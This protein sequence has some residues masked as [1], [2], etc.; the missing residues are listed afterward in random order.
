MA[1]EEDESTTVPVRQPGASYLQWNDAIAKFL[2]DQ[3]NDV[4]L[5]FL[6][7][8]DIIEI[9][10]TIPQL[11]VITE[12]EEIWRDFM[13]K[14]TNG[15]PGITG[16][17]QDLVS[18]A[19]YACQVWQPVYGQRSLRVGK[20]EIPLKY[21]P[22]ICLLLATVLPRLADEADTITY[23]KYYGPLKEFWRCE[24]ANLI[25]E[26]NFKE[27]EPVWKDLVAW[28]IE[29]GGGYLFLPEV[30]AGKQ[31]VGRPMS[32]CP[33][34]PVQLRRLPGL[35]EAAE[36]LPRALQDRPYDDD[37][38]KEAFNKHAVPCLGITE[39]RKKVLIKEPYLGPLLSL[40]RKAHQ[41]WDGEDE[42]EDNGTVQRSS[43]FR[44]VL[45][46][47]FKEGIGNAEFSYRIRTKQDIPEDLELKH[48]GA[49]YK[50]ISSRGEWT[51][52]LLLPFLED[53]LPVASDRRWK[54]RAE[55]M[56]NGVGIFVRG[57]HYDLPR[58]FWIQVPS[59]ERHYTELR[60][61]CKE[62]EAIRFEE[63]NGNGAVVQQLRTEGLPAGYAL[64]KVEKVTASHPDTLFISL[65]L[66]AVS[67]KEIQ[68]L[69]GVTIRGRQHIRCYLDYPLP[70]FQVLNA[71]GSETL[72]L[73]YETEENSFPLEQHPVLKDRWKLP[74]DI[75]VNKRFRVS[76][77]GEGAEASITSSYYQLINTDGAS[78]MV[79]D[80]LEKGELR[81]PRR[82]RD[83]RRIGSETTEAWTEGCVV[84]GPSH[85]DRYS[86]SGVFAWQDPGPEMAVS[87]QPEYDH[88]KI[89]N[90]LL[91]YLSLKGQ[92]EDRS[93]FRNAYGELKDQLFLNEPES[94]VPDTTRWVS[95]ARNYYEYLGHM[96]IEDSDTGRT[97]IVMNRPRLIMMPYKEGHRALLTGARDRQLIDK[98][99]QAATAHNVQV[100]IHEQFPSVRH[101]L[102][103]DAVILRASGADWSER[104]CACASMANIPF[105]PKSY[106]PLR[107][108]L[109]CLE[110][111]EVEETLSPAEGEEHDE[112]RYVF[113]PK[114]F[115]WNKNASASLDKEYCL[116][117]YIIRPWDRYC[118]LWKE[119]KRFAVD[120]NWG[121]FL[122]LKKAASHVV[123]VREYSG[124]GGKS[125]K[126]AYVPI[127]TPLP[128]F[129]FR[130]LVLMSGLA[131]DE[132]WLDEVPYRIFPSVP[133]TFSYNLFRKLGQIEQVLPDN[134][135]S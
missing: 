108:Y 130:A 60:V 52:P 27:L 61:L 44:G 14:A 71:S 99:F 70:E 73:S 107:L 121:R 83:G 39:E 134:R 78:E 59:I 82:R 119:E 98:L 1:S 104:M 32:Q 20:A 76:C 48:L 64:F 124:R 65:Q 7:K 22:Y 102:L 68:M 23:G 18:K 120:K 17:P 35:F 49:D 36:L 126:E 116:T 67:N 56:V 103:P 114:T 123:K 37:V 69:G 92:G 6:S 31:Y 133:S 105:D 90:T 117:E 16:T 46:L 80:R 115:D 57:D 21:P 50:V 87:K 95:V 111:S 110:A 5:L 93:V 43:S 66:A 81:I 26:T 25:D 86:D 58:E 112:Q 72:L 84:K 30:K 129:L 53:V 135:Q 94:A 34:R 74:P 51:K 63:W 88:K 54:F 131:P 9:G 77:A 45:H 55:P 42:A 47:Q 24:G 13:K 101:I 19:K 97:R 4:V 89:G 29:N 3:D 33:L 79:V 127:Q 28:S 122:A 38:L 11:Q 10:R 132:A 96:E 91:S 75:P 109:H 12:A 100:E 128:R 62:D 8:E 85:Y 113:D 2:F 15:L 106:L 118:W 125:W 41:R 40:I